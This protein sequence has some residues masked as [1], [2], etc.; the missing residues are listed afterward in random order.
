MSRGVIYTATFL[1]FVNGEHVV[2]VPQGY[3]RVQINQFTSG[4]FND[5]GW[6]TKFN[7]PINVSRTGSTFLITQRFPINKPHATDPAKSVILKVFCEGIDTQSNVVAAAIVG[8]TV[9][10][11][12]NGNPY[13]ITNRTLKFYITNEVNELVNNTAIILQY[14]FI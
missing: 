10:L 7:E 12:M 2:D 14:T 13:K 5:A 4:T 11:G 1:D 9:Y 3:N 8:E 6:I